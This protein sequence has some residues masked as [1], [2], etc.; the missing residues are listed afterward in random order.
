[1]ASFA[2]RWRSQ[3]QLALTKLRGNGLINAGIWVGLSNIINI[4]AVFV[5]QKVIALQVGPA[6]VAIVGQYQNFLGI[7]I[8]LANGGINSGIVKYV[9]EYRRDA[10]RNAV[11]I[12]NATRVT[13]FCSA[14]LVMILM[15][16]AEPLSRYLFQ[17][18]AYSFILRLLGLTITLFALNTLLISVLN[19]FGEIRKYAG[20]AIARSVVGILLTVALSL[21][22]N[23]SGALVAL[24]IVQSLVF[25]VTLFFVV[26]SPWFTSRFFAQQFDAAVTRKLLAFSLMALTSAVL[27]PLVQIL[28]RNH[29]ITALSL[30]DA[31]YWDAMWKISQGYLGIITGTLS[32]YYMPKLSNLQ[33]VAAIR[34]EIW[35]GYKL[36]VPALLVVLPLVYVLRMPIIYLLY[37]EQFTLT[38]GLFLPMLIGDFFKIV[39][40]LVAFLMLAKARTRMFIATQIVFSAITYALSVLMVNA[41]GLQGV[42]WAHAVNYIILTVVVS[43]LLREYLFKR[44]ESR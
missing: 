21:A 32:V 17:A 37:S 35:N 44:Y 18:D 40:W 19:G 16:F 1:M 43:Y 29:I 9:A 27:V 34:R 5:V 15:L 42:A 8:S 14:I 38:A 6:G 25:F 36:I 4:A 22:W 3:I 30:K 12:S 26:R 39:S 7:T 41:W 23:L 2:L 24:T 10:E 31:G 33:A 13:L 11:L 28:V 20:S